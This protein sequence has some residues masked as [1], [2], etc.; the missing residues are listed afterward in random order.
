VGVKLPYLLFGLAG[1]FLLFLVLLASDSAL[2]QPVIRTVQDMFGYGGP[3]S[4]EVTGSRDLFHSGAP[5][6]GIR[7]GETYGEYDSRR[8][9]KAAT[10]FFGFGCLDDCRGQE[11]G[12]RW[13]IRHNVSDPG[14]CAGLTWAFLE[15][16]VAYAARQE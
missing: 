9:R 13:A 3:H 2:R 4:D 1:G 12:Y 15:G 6:G 5:I 11:A 10:N 16:C 8:D 14:D 7:A